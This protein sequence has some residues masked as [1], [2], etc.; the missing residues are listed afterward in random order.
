MFDALISLPVTNS[1]GNFFTEEHHAQF[2]D[3]VASVFVGS[4]IAR[5]I[6]GFRILLIRGEGGLIANSGNLRGLVNLAKAFY[7]VGTVRLEYLGETEML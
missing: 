3:Y 6:S 4:G 7:G 1:Q 2:L 5:P